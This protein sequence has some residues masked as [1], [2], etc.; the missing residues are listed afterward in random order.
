M[1]TTLPACLTSSFGDVY[2]AI[3]AGTAMSAATD[4][5]AA[6]TV[7]IRTFICPPSS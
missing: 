4:A 5:T 2:A 7:Q 6:A 3:A 1:V